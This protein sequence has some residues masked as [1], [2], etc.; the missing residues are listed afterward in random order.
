MVEKALKA[1]SLVEMIITLS[2]MAL[3]CNNSELKRRRRG[4]PHALSQINL[5]SLDL[6]RAQDKNA[7]TAMEIRKNGGNKVKT[8][9]Y[10]YLVPRKRRESLETRLVLLGVKL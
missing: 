6:F 4:F 5:S 9:F 10:Y 3:G 8:N 2:F 1:V 7:I